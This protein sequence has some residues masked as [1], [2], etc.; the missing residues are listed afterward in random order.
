MNH[1]A[2]QLLAGGD[3]QWRLGALLGDFVKGRDV[4]WRWPAA[5]AAGIE[6]HRALDAWTDQHPL[7][8]AA[9]QRAPQE[10]RRYM[11]I[12]LDLML[13]AWLS[14]HWADYCAQP[15]D[16]FAAEVYQL[17]RRHQAQFP[18]R[19]R[20]FSAYAQH[21]QLLQRYGEAEVMDQVLA[22]VA[23]RLSRPGPLHRARVLLLPQQVFLD[24]TFAEFFPAARRWSDQWVALRKSTM[25][26]S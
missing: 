21:Y 13:D 23:Q 4:A 20:R 10:L 26:G 11:G 18:E 8:R 1:L 7:I 17:M 19:L 6:Q 25:T 5:I 3:E 15:L 14:R 24:A 2:H 22:G 16:E 12:V 9:R